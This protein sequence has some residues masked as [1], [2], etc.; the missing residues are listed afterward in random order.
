MEGG[1]DFG[2]KTQA[3]VIRFIKHAKLSRFLVIQSSTLFVHI[4][5]PVKRRLRRNKNFHIT[6]FILDQ[7]LEAVF[8]DFVNRNTSGYHFLVPM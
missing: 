3:L 8:H 1:H 2:S 5:R 6:I 4:L 7:P